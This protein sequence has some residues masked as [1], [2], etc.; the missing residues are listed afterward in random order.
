MA[1]TD[2]GNRPLSPHLTVFRWHIPMLTSILTR[3][4]GSDTLWTRKKKRMLS[5]AS[6]CGYSA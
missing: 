2:P 5:R 1:E 3:V 6:K 4:S